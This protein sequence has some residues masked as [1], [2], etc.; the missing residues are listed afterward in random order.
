M[1]V[2]SW[3]STRVDALVI[4]TASGLAFVSGLLAPV[5][6]GGRAFD[7]PAV[8]ALCALTALLF[9]R[10]RWPGGV[11]VACTLGD[12]V[13]AFADYELDTFGLLFIAVHAVGR[14]RDLPHS[15]AGL[16][17]PLLVCVLGL[18]SDDASGV[19]I[20]LFGLVG[21]MLWLLGVQARQHEASMREA[22]QSQAALVRALS[23][24]EQRAEIAREVH[25]I[26]AHGLGA[27]GIQ[28]HASLE[29]AHEEPE[30]AAKALRNIAELSGHAMREL[31]SLVRTLR[32]PNAP[33]SNVV[34]SPLGELAR[35]TRAL[36]LDVSLDADADFVH[37]APTLKA[38]T[39]RIVQEAVTNVVRHAG[40]S[41]VTIGVRVHPDAVVVEVKDDGRGGELVIGQGLRGIRERAEAQGGHAEF[42]STRHGVAVVAALPLGSES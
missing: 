24:R 11:L 2:R 22:T 42:S 13:L 9:V 29:V 10:H 4:L 25:D 14:W 20:A 36:G 40:A 30:T 23:L 5:P 7:L 19:S 16:A 33:E 12:L 21:G 18:F 28:A 35:R 26:V 15:A 38:A 1:P 17:A 32:E 31:R 8:L 39:Y 3:S 27:I 41:R 37:Q 6:P 34:E